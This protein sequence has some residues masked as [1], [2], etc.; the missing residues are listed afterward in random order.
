MNQ[1]TKD[2]VSTIVCFQ[3]N[4]GKG[5]MFLAETE[6]AVVAM[7]L[8]ACLGHVDPETPMGMLAVHFAR[9]TCYDCELSDIGDMLVEADVVFIVRVV[10]GDIVVKILDGD[11]VDKLEPR[12]L[13]EW[14]LLTGHWDGVGIPTGDYHGLNNFEP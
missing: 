7:D 9:C 1:N 12:D 2:P 14:A 11:Q 5:V 6:A 8:F 4:D 13:R 3:E 10:R